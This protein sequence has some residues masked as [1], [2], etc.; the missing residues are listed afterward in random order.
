MDDNKE[1]QAMS[2]EQKLRDL[3][4]RIIAKSENLIKHLQTEGGEGKHQW[5]GIAF[6]VV[7]VALIVAYI[8]YDYFTNDLGPFDVWIGGCVASFL[9]VCYIMD[10]VMRHFLSRMKNANTTSQFYQDVK[11]LITTQKLRCWIP[12]AFGLICG[13]IAVIGFTPSNSK[14]T[15]LLI[16]KT[17]VWFLFWIWGSM[18]YNWY[19]D[20]DFLNDVEELGEYR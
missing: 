5:L 18:K 7:V 10:K 11:R 4:Q 8:V 19:L 14:S 13:Y 12:F 2:D 9:I 3:Q 6:L 15:F 16:I 1:P 17:I 20:D